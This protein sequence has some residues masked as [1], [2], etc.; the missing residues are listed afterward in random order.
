MSPDSSTSKHG[1]VARLSK[2]L[3]PLSLIF[4]LIEFFDEL[5]YGV[6]GAV[7]PLIRT[8]LGLTYSQVGLLLG[9]PSVIAA[10]GEPIL[11][12]LGDTRFRRVLVLSGG[13]MMSL[14]LAS[15]AGT[16]SFPMLLFALSVVYPSSGAFVSLSQ[17]TLMDLH[18]ERETKMMA[19][20]TFSGSLANVL[21]PLLAGAGFVFGLGWRWMYVLV[22]LF[23]LGLV[24][25]LLP[26]SFP[27]QKTEAPVSV[28]LLLAHLKQTIRKP[29]MIRWM[30]LLQ[31]SDLMLDIFVGYVALYF[32]DVVGTSPT[33]ASLALGALMVSGLVSD[34]LLIPLLERF[35]G[36]TIVR[37]SAA[38]AAILFV[39]W[40]AVPWP[41]A[42]FA[43]LPAVGT[44]RL[45]WYSVL[46]GE[47]FATA[48]GHSGAVSSLT[49]LSSLLG[50]AMAW[51]IGVFAGSAGLQVALYLLLAGPLALAFFVPRSEVK[52]E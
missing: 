31:F 17:A 6:Q 13:L 47:A 48:P 32:I 27:Q 52:V 18:P 51:L 34:A 23:G 2:T 24:V 14:A 29:G 7:M 11:L 9:L 4:L 19:R 42:K 30:L 25:A 43:L 1:F 50:G 35:P 8:D 41:Q 10:I 28:A 46:K 44:A 26:R 3:L 22:A 15:I 36:R 33:V 40:L 21:G 37:T 20:W 39:A 12:L 5:V 49:S 45:G 16:A 38:V